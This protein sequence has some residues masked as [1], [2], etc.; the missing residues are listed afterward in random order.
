M[1]GENSGV[2]RAEPDSE[3]LSSP[4]LRSDVVPIGDAEGPALLGASRLEVDCAR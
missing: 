1:E 4:V 3:P 2:K